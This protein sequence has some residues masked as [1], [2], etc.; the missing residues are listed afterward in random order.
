M[1]NGKPVIGIAGGIGSGKSF[2]ARVFDEQ[3]C[4]VI[5]S[6]QQVREAYGDPRVR[7]ALR[8]WW[9]DGVFNPDGTVNR[10]AIAKQVF[11]DAAERRRLEGLLHPL[12]AVAREREMAARA[13]DP[14]VFAFAWDTPLLFEVGLN[15]GCDAVVFVDAPWDIRLERVQRTRGWD[16]LE[17]LR[18]EKLQMDLDRK[19]ELSDYVVTNTA[20]AGSVRDQVRH[21]LSR[22]LA[23][24][25]TGADPG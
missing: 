14:Q 13:G 5:D 25:K 20:D 11:T 2:V 21:V 16:A 7:D 24:S 10:S 18:R 23:P 19:K 9:G 22:I 1:Y 8:A 12:V 4:H 6:D 17:L 3:G 15:A